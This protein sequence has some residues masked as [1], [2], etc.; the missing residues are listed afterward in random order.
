MTKNMGKIDRILR[1]ILA[2]VIAVL[3]ITG[4]LTGFTAVLLGIFAAVF[5]LTSSIA[6]CPLYTPFKISTLG[7]KKE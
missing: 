3:I 7:K 6:V 4:K 2:L 1:I 5:I